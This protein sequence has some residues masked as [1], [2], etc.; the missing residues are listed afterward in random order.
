MPFVRRHVTRRLKVAKAE[1]DKELH[2]VTNSITTFFEENLREG[3]HESHR[4]L[5]DREYGRDRDRDSRHT[6]PPDSLREPFVLNPADLRSA[7][8]TDESGSD[9]GY[10]AELDYS[11]NTRY[12]VASPAQEE[13]ATHP[14]APSI[15]INSAP[16]LAHWA[17]SPGL[18]SASSIT[19]SPSSLRRQHTLPRDKPLSSSIDLGPA[20]PAASATVSPPETGNSRKQGSIIPSSWSMQRL[21]RRL[22]RTIHIPPRPAQSSHSSRSTSRSRS[23]LP[24]SSTTQ[25]SHSEHL[26][27]S[28][29]N[30]RSSRILVDDPIDPIMTTLYALIG[31]ATDIIDMTVPQLTS[32][33][34][35]CEMLVQRVQNIGKAWDEHPDWHGRNWY[36]QVLLAVASLSRVVEWWE[37]EKQFWNFDDNDDEQDEPLMFVTK[38][39]DDNDSVVPSPFKPPDTSALFLD[40]NKLGSA[41]PLSHGRKSRD[42]QPK[43]LLASGAPHRELEKPGRG[44]KLLDHNESA[45]ILATERLRLQAETAQ[46][47]NIILELNLDGDQLR[48]ANYAWRVVVG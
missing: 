34:K 14:P 5:R 2:R 40:E 4:E 33:P 43:S 18:L 45:R 16:A 20:S 47:Q 29:A 9:G 3:D 15:P 44:G 22:S 19:S 1:C 32:Q 6:D 27:T 13:D 36:V 30:R 8:Q 17:S 11:R 39:V 41:K 23:P 42:E 24:P 7:L 21:S 12:P 38:P 48:W 10:D 25:S 37:A 28:S 31:V 35:V 26:A 46:N